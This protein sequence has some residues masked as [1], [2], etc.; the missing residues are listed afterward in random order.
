MGWIHISYILTLPVTLPEWPDF[1]FGPRPTYF[2]IFVL[3]SSKNIDVKQRLKRGTNKKS[4]L[5]K[6][7]F[8]HSPGIFGL[9]QRIS[10]R[11]AKCLILKHHPLKMGHVWSFV[12]ISKQTCTIDYSNSSIIPRWYIS[13]WHGS[14]CAGKHLGRHGPVMFKRGHC[15]IH[16]WHAISM[17]PHMV[18]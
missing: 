18:K 16:C 15:D 17:S 2:F 8:I 6:M 7:W 10:Q 11:K 12:D 9:E 1:S 3:R 14:P 13:R 5:D 4:W